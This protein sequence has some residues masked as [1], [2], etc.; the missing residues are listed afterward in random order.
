MARTAC[1]NCSASYANIHL[2]PN[3]LLCPFTDVSHETFGT[4]VS[5]Y[6]PLHITSLIFTIVFIPFRWEIRMQPLIIKDY[7]EN[8]VPQIKTI[9][10]TMA[11]SYK[12]NFLSSFF[13]CLWLIKPISSRPALKFPQQNLPLSRS[14]AS[15]RKVSLKIFVF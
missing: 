5:A 8:I 4:L 3:A 15:R 9:V 7:S 1:R 10:K 2:V 14:T 11:T 12:N 13:H 6:A